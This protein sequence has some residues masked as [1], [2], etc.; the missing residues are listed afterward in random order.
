MGWFG[1]NETD[2]REAFRNLF[3]QKQYKK[4]FEL[5]WEKHLSGKSI[6]VYSLDGKCMAETILWS[7][8][9][10]ELMYKPI[11]WA[12]SLAYIP[13]RWTE[14][15][16]ENASDLEKECYNSFVNKKRLKDL[17]K[18]GTVVKLDTPVM[19]NNDLEDDTFKCFSYGRAWAVNLKIFV[20]GITKEYI[21]SKGFRIVS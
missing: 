12:D 14:K 16:L 17:I 6:A 7:E 2:K 19:F 21:V 18:S 8:V 20:S 3:C 11:S 9:D 10:G 15:L 5:L 1:V 4:R 13:K